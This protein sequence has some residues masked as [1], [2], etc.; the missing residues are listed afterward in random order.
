MALRALSIVGHD[1]D[2]GRPKDDFYPT[3]LEAIEPLLKVEEFSLQVWE[4]ACGEGHISKV[5][6]AAGHHVYSSDLNDHGYGQDH[7]IDFLMAW[8][9]PEADIVTNPPF[10]LA[11]EFAR[12]AQ[13]LGT[14]KTA[15]LLKLAFLEGDR[16]TR[17]LEKSPLKKVWVFRKRITLTRR[18]APK[19]GSGMIA[20][21]WFVWQIGHE[22]P[23]TIGW[24]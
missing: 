19:R 18:G 17:W 15:L 8:Q 7:G 2:G 23:P 13:D 16:R 24:I 22:G 5:L 3:E 4:P 9:K 1:Q 20:F 12:H 11:E 14:R 21:A 10:K 6:E